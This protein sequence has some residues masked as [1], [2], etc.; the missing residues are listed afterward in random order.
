MMNALDRTLLI[1][2]TAWLFTVS[3][4]S[5]Q[6]KVTVVG[7][8]S[9]KSPNGRY[10][11]DKRTIV[12]TQGLDKRK[13]YHIG[14][15]DSGYFMFKLPHGYNTLTGVGYFDHGKHYGL[16]LPRGLA[17]VK[18]KGDDRIYYIGDITLNWEIVVVAATVE[19]GANEQYI[20]GVGSALMQS[21]Y[22]LYSK[23]GRLPV[24]V[25]NNPETVARFTR[26]L[27]VDSSQITTS[28]LYLQ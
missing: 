25:K 16:K 23:D 9:I 19:K 4:A 3:V 21:K 11:A 28:L 2:L 20:S 12:F 17:E 8:F 10:Y 14:R 18:T 24:T 5:A 26:N 13:L 1:L 27:E 15:K 7:R 6:E 22:L